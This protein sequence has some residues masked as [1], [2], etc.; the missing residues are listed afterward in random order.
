M[1]AA[2]ELMDGRSYRRRDARILE[3]VIALADADSEDE[4]EYHR[5]WARLF[6]TLI[7]LGWMPPPHSPSPSMVTNRLPRN[8]CH[9]PCKNSHR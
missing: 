1:R 4:A 9:P 5:A 2:R 6:K 8:P 7:D 3:A